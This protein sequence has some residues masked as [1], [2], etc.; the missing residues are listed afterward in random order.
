MVGIGVWSATKRSGLYSK[1]ASPSVTLGKA[2]YIW[3]IS[4]NLSFTFLSELPTAHSLN[5]D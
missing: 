2:N 1:N 3:E 4:Q 5:F